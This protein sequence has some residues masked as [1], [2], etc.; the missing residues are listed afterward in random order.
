VEY[1][2]QVLN[3]F[4]SLGKFDEGKVVNQPEWF[5]IV[6]FSEGLIEE[7]QA[8]SKNDQK[9][10]FVNLLENPEVFADKKLLKPAL[11]NL[12]SNAIKYSDEG[13]EIIFEIKIVE[14]QLVLKVQDSGI[15]IPE[16]DKAHLFELF[17]RAHN[18]TNI[19]GTGLGLHITKRYIVAMNGTIEFESSFGE[20]TNFYLKL[21]II[22]E[23]VKFDSNQI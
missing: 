11:A 5:D 9:I 20:G 2:T 16:E 15:G 4:L 18:T 1:L 21:P 22:N 10:V 6:A 23:E 19:Q 8:I 12:L 13:K 17:Y 3:D 14:G 7:M